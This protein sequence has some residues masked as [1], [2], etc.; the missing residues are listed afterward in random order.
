MTGFRL[1]LVIKPKGL[2]MTGS[3]SDENNT[4]KKATIK[5]GKI[6]PKTKSRFY[7][8]ETDCLAP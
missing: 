2:T 8:R 4:R 1:G 6:L 7:E 5:K 3:V